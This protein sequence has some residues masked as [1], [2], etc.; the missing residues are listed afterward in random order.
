M[1][2]ERVYH[3]VRLHPNLFRDWANRYVPLM[4]PNDAI[5]EPIALIIRVMKI[6]R[7]EDIQQLLNVC[8]EDGLMEILDD[9][10]LGEFSKAEY[11]RYRNRLSL[12]M[13]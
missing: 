10:P 7:A 2:R 4:D 5:E 11:I 13:V 9:A 8:G 6:G 1:I 12:M 3:L